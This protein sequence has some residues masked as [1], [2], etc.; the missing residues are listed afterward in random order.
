MLLAILLSLLVIVP[1]Q[2]SFG[3]DPDPKIGTTKLFTP[4]AQGEML[5]H[6]LY[7]NDFES[8]LLSPLL[9][10]WR[11]IVPKAQ[12]KTNIV[13]SSLLPTGTTRAS[14]VE[15]LGK[16]A[17]TSAHNVEGLRYAGGGDVSRVFSWYGS[18]GLAFFSGETNSPLI[19]IAYDPKRDKP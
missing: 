12:S 7:P 13:T 15:R 8:V 16:S 14:V 2:S 10:Q 11:E 6:K 18:L 19:G 5:L 9:D 3:G 1:L 17:V 4:G